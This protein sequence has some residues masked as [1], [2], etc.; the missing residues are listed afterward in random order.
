MPR[1]I[2]LQ[3]RRFFVLPCMQGKQASQYNNQNNIQE[4][5]LVNRATFKQL[6][7]LYLLRFV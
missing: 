4:S 3:D 5:A 6:E 2:D 7:G 1:A